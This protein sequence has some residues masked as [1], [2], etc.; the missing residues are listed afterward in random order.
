MKGKEASFNRD[1]SCF[2]DE[3]ILDL[4]INFLRSGLV[5]KAILVE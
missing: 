2:L 3:L 1:S 5:L 4:G